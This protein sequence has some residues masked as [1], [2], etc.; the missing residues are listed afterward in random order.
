MK[1]KC[2]ESLSVLLPH[3]SAILDGTDIAARRS[4]LVSANVSSFGKF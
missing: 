1:K 4:W 3:P 2:V